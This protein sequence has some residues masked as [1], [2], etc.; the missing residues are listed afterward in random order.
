M[1]FADYVGTPADYDLLGWVIMAGL[2]AD[3]L[4]KYWRGSA[5]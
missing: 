4:Y 1:M 5:R 3:T 2:L